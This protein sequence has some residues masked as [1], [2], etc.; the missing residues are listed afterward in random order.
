MDE[1][2]KASLI[3]PAVGNGLFKKK[4]LKIL[5]LIIA[6]TFLQ[7]LSSPLFKNLYTQ[8]YIYT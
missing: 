5:P 4:T 8:I 6:I 7:L 1:R 2:G 3:N